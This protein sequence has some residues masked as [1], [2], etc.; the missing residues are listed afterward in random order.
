MERFLSEDAT[1]TAGCKLALDVYPNFKTH[2]EALESG[3]AFVS[4]TVVSDPRLPFGHVYPW[5]DE[6]ASLPAIPPPHPDRL[7]DCIR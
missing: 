2:R 1:R 7:E 5:P 3:A 4:Q 6:R